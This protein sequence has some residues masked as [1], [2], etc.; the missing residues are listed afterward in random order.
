MIRE[1]TS[2]ELDEVL[3]LYKAG[4]DE[5]GLEWKES[6]LVK[7]ITESFLLAPC[8]LLVIDGKIC[9]MAGFTVIKTSHNG[10]ATLADYM[11]YVDPQYRNIQNL[12]GLVREAQSFAKS[13]NLS[14]RVE[15]LCN[16]DEAL[17]RRLLKMHDFKVSA[18][19]GVY[20]G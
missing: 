1:A 17:K 14:L 12:G 8:F 16:D 20:D 7:K 13:H 9:G 19:V 5:L 4:C 15:F 18:I 10:D 3:R 6:F 11:F 2:S